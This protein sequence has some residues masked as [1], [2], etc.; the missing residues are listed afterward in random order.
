MDTD[1]S[2]V[3]VIPANSAPQ[4]VALRFADN[5]PTQ[6]TIGGIMA[7]LTPV[8]AGPTQVVHANRTAV[9]CTSLPR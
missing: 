5:A 9:V 6:P 7:C 8:S 1:I 3:F 2:R 4:T